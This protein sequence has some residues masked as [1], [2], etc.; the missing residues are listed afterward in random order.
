MVHPLAIDLLRSCFKKMKR[1]RARL[2]QAQLY[3]GREA[4]C[5]PPTPPRPLRILS[6]HR[7]SAKCPAAPRSAVGAGAQAHDHLVGVHRT[8]LALLGHRLLHRRG[9]HSARA[10][11]LLRAIFHPSRE[12]PGGHRVSPSIHTTPG[13]MPRA[14][15]RAPALLSSR[16]RMKK[17]TDGIE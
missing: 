14:I 17:R 15:G 16:G 11:D 2:Q 10:H 3:P 9:A 1:G 5:L 6:S 4:E 8:H 12:P 7:R 13:W